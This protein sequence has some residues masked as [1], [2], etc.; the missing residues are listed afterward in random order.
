MKVTELQCRM[1]KEN[2]PLQEFDRGF[3]GKQGYDVYCHEC[4]AERDNNTEEIT[5]KACR[6][7]GEVRSISKFAETASTRDGYYKEC[8]ECQEANRHRRREQRAQ[9]VWKGDMAECNLC[10]MLKPTYELGRPRYTKRHTRYCY[11]CIKKM[12][13]QWI[14]QYQREREEH[15]WPLL[16]KCK[17]CGRIVRSDHFYLDRRKKDGFAEYCDTCTEERYRDRLT[18]LQEKHLKK[19]VRS[20]AK[21]ECMICR[22]MK[23][24]SNFSKN[25]TIADGLNQMCRTCSAQIRREDVQIWSLQRNKKGIAPEELECCICHRILPIEMFT[26]SKHRKQGYR[27][28][29]KECLHAKE[30]EF[31]DRWAA[32]REQYPYEFSLFI[33]TEKKCKL[34]GKMLPL[35]EF[36]NRRASKDGLNHYCKECNTLRTKQRNQRLRKRGF[37][38]ELIPAKRQC[39]HCKRI[40]PQTSFSRDAI[41]SDG[42]CHVCKDCM[43]AYD[44][45]YRTRPEVKQRVRAYGQR[46]EVMERKRLAARSYQKKPEVKERVRAYKKE[47]K[48]RE[49]VRE[50]LRAYDRIR[51][52]RPAVKQRIKEYDSR[53]EAKARRNR[54]TAAWRLR[55][56]AEQDNIIAL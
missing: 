34:C 51:R 5:K 1:C 35:T 3:F 39:Q 42:L 29:C 33:A 14:Q 55:K 13:D 47:Y 48:K 8:L 4:R 24:V 36:W 53:P 41:A 7:C 54:S 38:E 45:Q 11:E 49:Y 44:K 9:A 2:K 18:M 28:I 56:K 43:H 37:P 26:R 15:G 50:K 31:F 30:N 20:N 32:Q 16:K 12:T 27:D 46:P 10:G 25:K 22:V 40:L 52:Q 21:K 19:P 23:P 17:G 6:Q